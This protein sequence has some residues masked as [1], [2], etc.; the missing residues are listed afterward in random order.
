MYFPRKPLSAVVCN[1]PTNELTFIRNATK[2]EIRN[3]INY[4][5]IWFCNKCHSV[6]YR[7]NTRD[8]G[9]MTDGYHT[10]NELYHHRAV[11]TAALFH[12]YKDICWKSM[13]HSDGT[14]YDG[15]FI[16]GINTPE[17]QATYHYD[18][19]PYWFLFDVK[20]LPKAPEYDG[21]TPNDAIN[22]IMSLIRTCPPKKIPE[23]KPQEDKITN[24]EKQVTNKVYKRK[25]K[26]LLDFLIK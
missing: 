14:M 21:H 18:L 15:M 13:K 19:E 1:H 9:E 12:N 6:V 17:G 24:P 22:R 20:E 5:S 7:N 2:K 10:F 3:H 25:N 8:I 11:L 16:V 4:R 26:S 23:E